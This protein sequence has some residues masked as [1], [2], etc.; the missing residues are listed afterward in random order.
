MDNLEFLVASKSMLKIKKLLEK[1]R[2]ITLDQR[3]RNAIIYDISKMKTILF[4]NAQNKKLVKQ[5][6]DTQLELRVQT[7]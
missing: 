5:L 2:K 4:F 3:I 6:T 1:A 7:I